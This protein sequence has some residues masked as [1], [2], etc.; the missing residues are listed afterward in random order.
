MNRTASVATYTL[1][2][3]TPADFEFCYRLNECNMRAL[4]ERLRGWDE[5]AERASF[6]TQFRAGTDAIVVVGGRD[7][8]Y[9]GVDEDDGAGRTLLSMIALAPEIQRRGIGTAIIRDVLRDAHAAGRD[10]VLRVTEANLDARRLYERL[11]FRAARE[12][13]EPEKRMR[14]IEMVVPAPPTPRGRRS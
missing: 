13:D 9:L 3:S 2:P 5:A 10:V 12:L 4:V 8:G 1:R 11:G 14:K 7:V 6:A